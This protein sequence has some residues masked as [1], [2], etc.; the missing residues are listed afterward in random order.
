[1]NDIG[2]SSLRENRALNHNKILEKRSRDR[3]NT[4]IRDEESKLGDYNLINTNQIKKKNKNKTDKKRKSRHEYQAGRTISN[5]QNFRQPKE[6]E[7]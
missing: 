3:E 2:C 1:M 7:Q 5:P 4:V 6:N